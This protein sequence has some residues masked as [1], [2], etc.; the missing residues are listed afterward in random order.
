MDDVKARSEP[1]P[2]VAALLAN[3]LSLIRQA[4]RQEDW[5]GLRPCHVRLLS[6]LP[7]AGLSITLLAER[8]GMTK[9]GCGQFVSALDGSGRVQVVADSTDRR[10]RVVRRTALGDRTV[11]AV[12]NRIQRI[13]Q[14]WSSGVGEHHYA[15]FRRVM[16]ELAAPAPGPGSGP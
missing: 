10:A 8:L 15:A 12:E 14:D 5:S 13:E 6:A 16:A 7:E 9:Q 4:F 2:H 3:I 1:E 11:Q